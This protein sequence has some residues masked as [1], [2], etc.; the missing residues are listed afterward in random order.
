MMMYKLER[1][2]QMIPL[3]DSLLAI[4]ADICFLISVESKRQ[5]AHARTYWLA[6]PSPSI[7]G[8]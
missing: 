6:S 7:F 8:T 2:K 5:L 4:F 3:T 1:T